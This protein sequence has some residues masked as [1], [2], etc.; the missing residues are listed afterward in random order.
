MKKYSATIC[1]LLALSGCMGHKSPPG[2]AAGHETAE[3]DSHAKEIDCSWS[4]P[5]SV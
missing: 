4:V 1:L 2:P 3:C 5:D